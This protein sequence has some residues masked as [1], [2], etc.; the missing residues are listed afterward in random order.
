MPQR[1]E[2]GRLEV[3]KQSSLEWVKR[4]E[5]EEG[6]MTAALKLVGHWGSLEPL[7]VTGLVKKAPYQHFVA[8]FQPGP[9]GGK[10]VEHPGILSDA[11]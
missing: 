7:E 4:E 11:S 1:L 6:E 10:R 2:L 3:V 9:L 5:M 8:Y